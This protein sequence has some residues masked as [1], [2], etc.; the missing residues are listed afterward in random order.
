MGKFVNQYLKGDWFN[1]ESTA[2]LINEAQYAKAENYPIEEEDVY[3]DIVRIPEVHRID[4]NGKPIEESTVCWIY[5]TPHRS[6]A[7]LRGYQKSINAEIYMDE[8]T[9]NRLGVKA[10]ESYEFRFK[11]ARLWGQLIWAWKASETGYRVASRLAVIGLI[12]GL[13][14]F[15][16]VL[17]DWGKSLWA[18]LK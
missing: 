7:V 18:C 4:R 2:I 9:R 6:I 3:K 11:R 17:I 8:R 16:P 13:L 5:G 14:A 1:S 12:L 10:G 15:I